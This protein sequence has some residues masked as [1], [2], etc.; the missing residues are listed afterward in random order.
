MDSYPSIEIFNAD[1][2][3]LTSFPILG[4]SKAEI[5]H[6][7]STLNLLPDIDPEGRFIYETAVPRPLADDLVV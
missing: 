1:Q 4:L 2:E 6:K 7:L 5:M 3:R